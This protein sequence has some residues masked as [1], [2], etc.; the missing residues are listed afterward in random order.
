MG[1]EISFSMLDVHIVVYEFS[2]IFYLNLMM[3]HPE[4]DRIM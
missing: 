3:V 2:P 1:N 4:R